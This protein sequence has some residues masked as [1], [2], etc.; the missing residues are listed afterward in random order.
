LN[1]A[2]L[3]Y[4]QLQGADLSNVRLDGAGLEGVIVE[5]NDLRANFNGANWWAALPYTQETGTT[6]VDRTLLLWLVANFPRSERLT[7]F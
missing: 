4:A 3:S 1:S 7:E 2:D 6:E 5:K